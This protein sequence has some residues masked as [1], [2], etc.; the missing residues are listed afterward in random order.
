MITVNWCLNNVYVPKGY[1]EDILY[2]ESIENLEACERP[3][4]TVP[5]VSTVY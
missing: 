5:I 2:K 3:D 1:I 4:G